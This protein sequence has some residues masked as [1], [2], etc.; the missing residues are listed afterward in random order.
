[1]L[2]FFPLEHVGRK[3]DGTDGCIHGRNSSVSL[4]RL[5]TEDPIERRVRV[6]G[7]L[8]VRSEVWVVC[9]LMTLFPR[10]GAGLRST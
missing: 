2:Y 9:D 6:S 10:R 3:K 5:Y 8:Y 1:M 4:S 7:A